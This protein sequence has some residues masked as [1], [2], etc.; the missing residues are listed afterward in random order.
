MILPTG[1]FR[2]VF[3]PKQYEAS[4]AFYKQGLRLPVDH[5]WDYGGGDRGVV[6]LAGGGM[7]ELLG[8]AP[9]Q[10]YVQPQG[11]GMLIQVDDADRWLAL[12][13]ERG[14]TVIQEPTSY[15]WGHRIVRLADPDGLV[16]SLFSII[17][18]NEA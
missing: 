12:A 9:G 6:F 18:T 8:L 13:R 10:S 2:L 4:V 11:V 7:I 5:E 14:L 1:Q 15:P 17:Q 16:V 3:W